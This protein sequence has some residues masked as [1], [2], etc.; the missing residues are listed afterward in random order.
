M[1]PRFHRRTG[2]EG[3][4]S[5]VGCLENFSPDLTTQEPTTS[6]GRIAKTAA[7]ET[8]HSTK[9]FIHL[10]DVPPFQSQPGHLAMTQEHVTEDMK[11]TMQRE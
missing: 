8:A 5:K 9:E 3:G 4:E 11:A 7:R 2:W 10:E 6:E 1:L